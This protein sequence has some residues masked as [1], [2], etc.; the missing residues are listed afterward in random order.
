M[1]IDW[2]LASE[3][4]TKSQKVENRFLLDLRTK[5]DDLERQLKQKGSK[6]ENLT[7]ELTEI[8]EKLSEKQKELEE[9]NKNTKSIE[10][11]NQGP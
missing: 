5:I 1:S 2:Q 4:P 6:V 7:K 3:K 10:E 8:K 11:E 9:K